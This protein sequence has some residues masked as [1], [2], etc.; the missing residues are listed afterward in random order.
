MEH[1]VQQLYQEF[2]Q[3]CLSEIAQQRAEAERR[4]EQ[5]T[6]EYTVSQTAAE[7]EA[8]KLR[9]ELSDANAKLKNV[10]IAAA[11]LNFQLQVQVEELMERLN[12]YSAPLRS[13]LMKS[14]MMTTD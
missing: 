9:K 1:K 13:R 14:E 3:V 8:T 4:H 10:A 11:E 6:A 5:M 7:H 12:K 2:E